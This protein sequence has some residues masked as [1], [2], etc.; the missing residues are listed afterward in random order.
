MRRSNYLLI[1]PRSHARMKTDTLRRGFTLIEVL[2]VIGVIAVLL[3]LI[4]PAVMAARE[5]ARRLSCANNMKQVALSLQTYHSSN[6]VFP[7]GTP[8]KKFDDVGV[9]PGH[10]VFVSLLNELEE[11]SLYNSV[12]FSKNI[13]TYA[14]ITIQQAKLQILC[15]PSD[16]TIQ[17][18]PTFPTVYFDITDGKFAPSLS[19][20]GVSAGTWYHRSNDLRLCEKLSQYDNGIAYVNSNISYAMITDGLSNTMLLAERAHG[21][22]PDRSHARDLAH[23]WFDGYNADTLFWTLRP[24]NTERIEYPTSNADSSEI[25]AGSV[26]G[27]YHL[28]GA[29]FAFADGSV[30]FIKESIDSW[31]IDPLTGYP[32][33]VTG[34]LTEP[35]RLANGTHGGIYQQLSTRSGNEIIRHGEF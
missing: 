32:K 17:S 9:F 25:Y 18:H 4:L 3:G 6:A 27:S 22:L 13:Y 16:G 8:M 26:A 24:I 12:N 29:N 35:F 30:K 20:Y 2:V 23:W 21:R 5:T 15:C 7:M 28:G 19:S 11:S 10:S 1:H 14:N 34:G 31:S 33:G